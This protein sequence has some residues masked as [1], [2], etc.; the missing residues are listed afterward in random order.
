MKEA[1]GVKSRPRHL[2]ASQLITTITTVYCRLPLCQAP[3]GA[4]YKHWFA[5]SVLS[6]Y[7]LRRV[8]LPAPLTDEKTSHLSRALQPATGR[9]EALNPGR[10]VPESVLLTTCLQVLL[11]EGADSP[12]GWTARDTYDTHIPSQQPWEALRMLS[13]KLG[14]ATWL[15]PG[16]T[17]SKL[18]V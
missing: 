8:P 10:W 4:F 17:A 18:F 6:N 15:A 11:P 5:H 3:V 12:C 14:E 2:P 1:S 13:V 9:A 16:H 7:P